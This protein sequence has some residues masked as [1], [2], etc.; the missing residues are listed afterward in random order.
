MFLF[1]YVTFQDDRF[2][3]KLLLPELN[4]NKITKIFQKALHSGKQFFY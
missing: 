1:Y 2:F 4:F 3:T